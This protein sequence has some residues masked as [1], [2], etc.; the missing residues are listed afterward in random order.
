MRGGDALGLLC[1]LLLKLLNFVLRRRARVADHAGRAAWRLRG[2][3]V[4][5]LVK[6]VGGVLRVLLEAALLPELAE[7]D[8]VHVVLA[9]HG[10]LLRDGTGRRTGR[11]GQKADE[12]A[13]LNDKTSA[14]RFVQVL[15]PDPRLQIV[16]Y[17]P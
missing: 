6:E 1:E 7:L 17:S 13:S 9:A 4:V 10:F 11:L 16:K 15:V 8:V 3:A 2:G 12:R 5:A 14:T